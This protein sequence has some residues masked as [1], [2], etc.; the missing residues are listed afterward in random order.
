MI[1]YTNGVCGASALTPLQTSVL[2]LPAICFLS[3]HSPI[4]LTSRYLSAGS[5]RGKRSG[6]RLRILW[7]LGRRR[8]GTGNPLGTYGTLVPFPFFL[9][10]VSKFLRHVPFSSWVLFCV[11]TIPFVSKNLGFRS[12]L[13]SSAVDGKNFF[14]VGSV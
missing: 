3:E 7:S 12:G 11:P 13:W 8:I 9:F 6:R 14:F 4:L 5:R 2:S 10:V 1:F